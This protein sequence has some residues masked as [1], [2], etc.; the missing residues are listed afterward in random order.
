[1]TAIA[2][3]AQNAIRTLALPFALALALAVA[4]L[5]SSALAED[6]AD[7]ARAFLK[8]FGDAAVATLTDGR[9]SAE[10][11]EATLKD[12]INN[13]FEL[14]TIGRLAL[15]RHWKAAT[16][17]QRAEFRGLFQS[18]V[19]NATVKRLSGYSGEELD[20]G[21]ARVAGKSELVAVP[22]RISR[23][24]EAGISVEWRLRR[25]ADAKWR[26]IDV[27]I[28]GVSMLQ[29]HRAEFDAVIRQG[30]G[31]LE[32]LLTKLRSIVRA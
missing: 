28:E 32:V 30:G 31:G 25:G 21:P 19:T 17:S 14:D 18:Y 13:G 1:M 10:Q 27:V 7:E 9:L 4:A 6:P 29:T 5:P 2:A 12:L 11:R 3:L 15:G 20:L 23:P 24:G 8:S 16:E 26:I 22:S